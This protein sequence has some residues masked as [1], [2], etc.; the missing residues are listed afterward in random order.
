[1]TELPRNEAFSTELP[2]LQLHWDSTSLGAFKRCPR[3]YQLSIVE[4]WAPRH[5]RVDLEFGIEM[6]K[7]RE[8]YYH[9][10]AKGQTHDDATE[11]AAMY[12]LQATWDE[13]FS[14]P[15]L[16]DHP[17]KTRESLVRSIVWYCDTWR[18]DPLEQVILAS[19][20][21]A[22]ELSFG[23]GLGAQSTVT[24]ED[25]TL[26]G[27]LDRLVKFNDHIYVSDLKTTK[28]ELGA[29]F[30]ANFTPDNQMSLYAF[31][32]N[33]VCG[34]QVKGLIIDGVQVLA[35]L[36]RFARSAPIPRAPETLNE[37]TSDLLVWLDFAERCAE[38][39]SWPMNDKACFWCDFREIC[40][41]PPQTREQWLRADYVRRVWDPTKK[42]GD[43]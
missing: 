27:H 31:G 7:A 28:H 15:K 35:T 32:A 20:R 33:V 19:G 5:A 1:M 13:E 21:P 37:W 8:I 40:S 22:V 24:G 18:D 14:R 36:T 11:A 29:R 3:Y 17:T 12:A 2:S 41:K 30:F 4:G 42:R 25:F 39:G 43:V 16:W 9:E 34:E 26:C 6:H 10:R 23:F 38:R